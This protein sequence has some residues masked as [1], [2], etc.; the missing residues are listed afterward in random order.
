MKY[1]RVQSSSHTQGWSAF[2][3]TKAQD[4]QFRVQFYYLILYSTVFSSLVPDNWTATINCDLFIGS[5]WINE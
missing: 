4:Q 5:N 2:C 3:T 1:F